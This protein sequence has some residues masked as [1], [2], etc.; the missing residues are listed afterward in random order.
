MK[1]GSS[2]SRPVRSK[3]AVIYTLGCRLNQAETRLIE[4]Q[5]KSAGY[6]I[7][8]FGQKVDLGIIHTC[9]VTREA[10]A[11]SRKMIRRFVRD[12]PGAA[13]VVIGC[14]AQTAGDTIAAMEG[15]SLVLGNAAKMTLAEYLTDLSAAAPRIDCTRSARTLF[16]VPFVTVGDPVNRRVNLKIQDGCDAMC[17]Y[18]YIPF[19]RGRSRSR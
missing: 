11:K 9:V 18:C 5:L 10:E 19:A 3:R 6:E 7:V 8:P 4:D 16:T 12:N 13:V 14:Y 17:T 1:N 2:N 15:V